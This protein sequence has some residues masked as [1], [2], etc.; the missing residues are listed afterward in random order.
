M[1]NNTF[2]EMRLSFIIRLLDKLQE[3]VNAKYPDMKDRI[4]PPWDRVMDILVTQECLENAKSDD[5]DLKV[6]LG[7]ENN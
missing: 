6:F 2:R 7:K 5:P 4:N 3:I 1:R